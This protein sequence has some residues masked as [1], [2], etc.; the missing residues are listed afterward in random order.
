MTDRTVEDVAPHSLDPKK[1]SNRG[2]SLGKIGSA[3]H[4]PNDFELGS[5]AI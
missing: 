2:S 5:A 4:D 3:G 1:G